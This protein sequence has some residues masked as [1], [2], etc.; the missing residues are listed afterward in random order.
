MLWNPQSINN[1]INSFIQILLDNS[2][3]IICLC[4]TWFQSQ[5]NTITA[6]LRDAG[7]NIFH[8]NRT[9]KKG[10]GVAI[11]SKCD[12]KPKY[13]KSFKYSSFECVVQTL[14]TCNS[15]FGLTI[16]VI[17]RSGCESFNVFKEEFYAFTEYVKLN[18]KYFI[19]CGDFNIHINKPTNHDSVQ[20]MNILNTFSLNQAVDTSTHKLGNTLDLIIFDSDNIDI[21]NIIVDSTDTLN[22]DHSMIYFNVLCNLLMSKRE[23]VTY[24]NYNNMNMQQF[25][26]DIIEYTDKY[27]VDAIGTDFLSSVQLYSNMFG[28]VVDRHAPV[29]TKMA[30]ALDRPPWMDVEFVTARKRRRQLYKTWCRYK[31]PE[32][33]AIFVESRAAVNALATDKRRTFYQNS[34]SA[35][36]NSQKELFKLCNNLLDSNGKSQLPYSEDFQSLA[37]RFNN[38]FVDKIENIRLNFNNPTLSPR[39]DPSDTI[40]TLYS[41]KLVTIEDLQKQIQVHKIKTSTS[42]PIPAVILKKIIHLVLPVILHLINTSLSTGSMDGLKESIVTPILKK[43]GLDQDQL[44]NYRPVC[45]G[46]FIDKC[47]QGNVS[48]QLYKHMTENELHIP[49]QS[50][51]KPAH[52]CE[53][54]LLSLTNDILLNLDKGLCSVLMLLDN[55]AAFDT[56][57]HNEL[58]LDLS[59]D[60]GIRGTALN[61][62][63]SFLSGRTQATRVKGC[64]S[65]FVDTP[66][67]VP[68]GSVLGPILFN[69][70]VRKFIKLLNDAGFTV[71]GYA[72]D[73]QVTTSFR[74]EFQYSILCSKLPK[75][76][77]LISQFMNSRFLKLNAGKTKLLIFSPQKLCSEIYI[78]SVYV[79]NNVYLPVSK[80]E[81]SLGMKLD[82]QL[83]FSPQI[84]IILRQ[85]YR[86]ISNIGRIRKFLT[87]SDIQSIVQAVIIS[88]LDNCNSLFYGIHENELSKLQCLQN[89][90]ARLIYGRRKHDHVSDLFYKLHWLPI[91]QRIIFK[92][93]LFVFKIFLDICP[94]Y[95]KECVR[96]VDNDNRL[97]FIPRVQT[98]YGDRAFSNSA[99]RLWNAL[100]LR[101]RKSE[102]IV[103]FKAHLK[104][105]LFSNYSEFTHEVNKY[106]NFV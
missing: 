90:S 94:Q 64:N 42:D 75:L 11:L 26:S 63:K 38:Y 77:D 76:L 8:Q 5:K 56:V 47:I 6:Q 41:F 24:R 96:I 35:A 59:N 72:D 53:T 10:G 1:K 62:F 87:V 21:S 68:Q 49:Y 18:F 50:A 25:Q 19:M 13:E 52:S 80:E 30:N 86:F 97:L 28:S 57:D 23:E 55:S 100:P 51:Y 101:L 60:I 98:T 95:L 15:T 34:I 92:V 46:M 79:G 29:I 69:I 2:V 102:T 4:E 16:I 91:R 32:N 83:L 45:S 82:S 7:Y 44:S 27:V 39:C 105:H 36:N 106:R 66:Y 65:E 17:Y 88:R 43:A 74:I 81:T 9:D 37:S 54:V 103:Y 33:R 67:G 84:D 3:D 61:W 85:S 93:L 73:H 89:S 12:Y 58:I 48:G 31:T 70:Y 14:K 22:S 20:F 78:D 104:H 99:P 71:H 40:T